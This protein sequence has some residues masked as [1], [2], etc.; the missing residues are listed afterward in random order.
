MLHCCNA[1]PGTTKIECC[2]SMPNQLP[3][4]VY[5]SGNN[6]QR[7]DVAHAQ[8]DFLLAPVDVN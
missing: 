1:R 6:E 4:R 5:L 8:K 3:P 7:P 2:V